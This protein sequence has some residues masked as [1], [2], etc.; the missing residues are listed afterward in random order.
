LFVEELKQES[1]TTR[2]FLERLPADKLGFRPHEKSM[3]AGT[4]A[5][6]IAQIPSFTTAMAM[7]LD[8]AMAGPGPQFSEATSVEQV[9]AAHDQSVVDAAHRLGGLSDD[10]YLATWSMSVAGKVLIAMPR[11]AMVRSFV[12]SHL[13]QH[14]GQFGVFLRLMGAT[15]PWS[16]GPSGDELP[17][18]IAQAMAG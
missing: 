15:V 17:P 10:D 13:I 11:H 7:T 1:S 5:L 9:L 16:Y 8:F 4:L 6:H 14:R 3:S 2:R 12:F 18:F